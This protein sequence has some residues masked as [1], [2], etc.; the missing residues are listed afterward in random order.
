[1]FHQD[2]CSI[3]AAFQDPYA[4]DAPSP[5]CGDMMGSREA[6]KEE[7]RKM[8]RLQQQQRKHT[9][10]P[11]REKWIRTPPVPA[12]NPNPFGATEDRADGYMNSMEPNAWLHTKH[13]TQEQKEKERAGEINRSAPSFDHDPLDAYVKNEEREHVMVVPVNG[14][15]VTRTKTFFGA[16]GPE[17]DDHVS[18]SSPFTSFASAPSSVAPVSSD[19][20]F[21]DYVADRQDYHLEPSFDASVAADAW[22]HG[23]GN[24]GSGAV[25]PT[26]DMY[27][28]PRMPNGA[29]TAYVQAQQSMQRS[30]LAPPK[31]YSESQHGYSGRRNDADETTMEDIRRR[32][33]SLVA[34]LDDLHQPSPEQAT[35]ELLMFISTGIFVMFAMDML[36]KHGGGGG[37]MRF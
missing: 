10:D 28:K 29:H 11:D 26:V 25:A 32:I 15:G 33:D 13:R 19:E 22:S 21:A 37:R 27:W 31:Y 1:M 14:T 5:G 34:R 20:N 2:L 36:V 16:S 7:R 4:G 3:D 18:S 17:E 12:M 23:L 9:T 30:A 35:S 8:K 24:A 6:R